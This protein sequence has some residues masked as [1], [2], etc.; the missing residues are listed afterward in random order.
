MKTS[1][2]LLALFTILF[3]NS[4]VAQCTYRIQLRDTYGDGWNGGTIQSVQVNGV[5]VLS[6][7]ST[8]TGTGW[9]NNGTFTAYSGQ[10]I[11]ITYAPGSW[12]GENLYRI[13]RNNCSILQ[14]HCYLYLYLLCVKHHEFPLSPTL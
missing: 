3:Y 7:L 4:S 8:A 11:S 2:L 9:T 1:S 12:C 13:Q 5:T 10:T 6:N 14:L